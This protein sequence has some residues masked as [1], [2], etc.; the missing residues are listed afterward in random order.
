ML[1]VVHFPRDTDP[2]GD[3]SQTNRTAQ[4]Y[5]AAYG[6]TASAGEPVL[7]E[8]ALKART[9]AL[10]MR[11]PDQVRAFVERYGLR[12]KRVLEVGA[13]SGLLQDIA[14]DYTGLDI[15][16]AA[17]RHF[18]KPFVEASATDMPFPDG[19]FDA[20]WS[21]W[22]LEHIPNPERALAEMR[23]VVKNGGYLY[24]QP[25]W[26]CTPWAAN[27]YEVRPYSDFDFAGKLI[28]ASIPIRRSA[29][30]RM[31]Y[32]RQIRGLRSLGWHLSGTP[33]RLRFT[34]LTPNYEKFWVVDSDAAVS[35]DYHETLLWFLSRGDVC[36]NCPSETALIFSQ[37]RPDSMIIQV[38]KP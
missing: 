21:I 37:G 7:S 15:S 9:A 13:G 2:R 4:Y 6:G 28:K 31:L 23:R 29:P 12:D 10:E 22:T 34:R 24:L 14:A 11:I 36:M 27:G 38:R 17:R 19:S 5:D 33:T 3:E 8:Y 30:Y 16:P 35:L 26:N 32:S 1:T 25:A 20:L 18:H